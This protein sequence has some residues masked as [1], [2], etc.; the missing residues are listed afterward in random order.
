[1]LR[2]AQI[3]TLDQQRFD[4]LPRIEIAPSRAFAAFLTHGDPDGT[5]TRTRHQH[6]G[7]AGYDGILTATFTHAEV[8]M[9]KACH[10]PGD[11]ALC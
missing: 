3:L 5:W 2:W 9:R 7:N 8:K 10:E 6:R 1:M 11:A 4:S